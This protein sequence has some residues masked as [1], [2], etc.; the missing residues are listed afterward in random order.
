MVR[1]SHLL[2]TQH[3]MN[4]LHL[5]CASILL[6]EIVKVKYVACSLHTKYILLSVF[7]QKHFSCVSTSPLTRFD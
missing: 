6:A 5:N 7:L 4:T 2:C 3:N 1:G